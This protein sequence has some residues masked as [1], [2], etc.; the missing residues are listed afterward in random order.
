MQRG[1][2]TLQYLNV[3]KTRMYICKDQTFPE[4]RRILIDIENT[5]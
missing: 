5:E 3:V 4:F 2:H 1:N